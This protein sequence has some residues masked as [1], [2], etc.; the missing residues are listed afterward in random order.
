MNARSPKATFTFPSDKWEERGD[1]LYAWVSL[2]G[3]N[4]HMKAIPVTWEPE[5]EP[6]GTKSEWE[7]QVLDGSTEYTEALMLA[8]GAEGNPFSTAVINEKEYVIILTPFC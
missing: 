6:D 3:L 5:Y 4:M 7:R 1:R 8:A 2:N